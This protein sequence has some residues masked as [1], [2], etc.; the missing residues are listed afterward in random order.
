MWEMIEGLASTEPPYSTLETQTSVETR[1]PRVTTDNLYEAVN[2]IIANT[3]DMQRHMIYN[4]NYGDL[5]SVF[6]QVSDVKRNV[7]DVIGDIFDGPG[8]SVFQTLN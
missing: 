2:Q 1:F 4:K 6:Y 5:T 3:Y 7:D 8:G